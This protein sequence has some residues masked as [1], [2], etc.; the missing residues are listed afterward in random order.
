MI[1]DF[2]K[3]DSFVFELDGNERDEILAELTENLVAQNS[4]LNR[5]EILS[6]LISREEKKSTLVCPDLAVPH[7]VS[8][9]I[10][11]PVIAVGISRSGV[12]FD[13]ECFDHEKSI[14]KIVFCVIF[15]QSK[16]DLHLLILKDILFMVK[17]PNFIT[18]VLQCQTPSDVCDLIVKTG[19]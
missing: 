12:E 5:T 2:I 4:S 15:P 3:P 11:D 9:K 8:D 19:V 10:S 14:A 13:M 18:K 7:I 6:A 17:S 1:S 16:A